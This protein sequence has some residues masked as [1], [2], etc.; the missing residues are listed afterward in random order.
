MLEELH[1]IYDMLPVGSRERVKLHKVIRE[2][3][4]D[5]KAQTKAIPYPIL[6]D[7]LEGRN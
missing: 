5:Q 7:D 1:E 6:L 4:R 3:E 2:I